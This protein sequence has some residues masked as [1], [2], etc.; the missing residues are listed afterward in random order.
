MAAYGP[1]TALLLEEFPQPEVQR[2]L[3]RLEDLAPGVLEGY[4]AMRRAAL[5]PPPDGQLPLKVKE[6][7]ILAIECAARRSKTPPTSHVHKAM[8]AGA[9]TRE[10]AEVVSLCIMLTGMLTYQECGRFI[11]ED[12][13]AYEA[14][15]RSRE[16]GATLKE[17]DEE[18]SR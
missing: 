16:L 2:Y 8:D 3:G 10:I 1:D 6:L 18:A 9:T 4:A 13:E 14:S 7:V 11:L 5:R 15:S 17:L 12:A